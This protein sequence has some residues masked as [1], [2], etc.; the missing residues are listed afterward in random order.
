[1]SQS[2]TNELLNRLLTILYRS[3]PM[4]LKDAQPWSNGSSNSST[5]TLDHIVRDQQ[6][7]G[8]RI[9]GTILDSGGE[10]HLGDFPLQYADWNDLSLPFTIKIALNYQQQ[11]IQAIEQCLRD[12]QLAPAAKAL[13]E[14]VLG[15]AKGHLESLE[16]LVEQPA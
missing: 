1:M 4:Y 2:N 12:L 10:P 11:D 8:D 14:E 3:F 9:A 6:T 16:E 7:L 15:L 13:G 5:E